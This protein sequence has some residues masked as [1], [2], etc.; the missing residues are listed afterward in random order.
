MRTVFVQTM[1]T[2]DG[3]IAGPDGDLSWAPPGMSGELMEWIARSLSG[4]D[5]ELLGRRSYQ[6]QV[7]TWPA[8][9]SPLA[10]IINGHDK[11]VFTSDPSQVDPAA[12]SGTR[13]STRTPS[14]EVADLKRVAGR[15]I[16]VP[17]GASLIHHLI[18]QDL[19]DEYR[20]ITHPVA[21]GTGLPLFTAPTRLELMD[22]RTFPNGVHVSTY[23]PAI[24]PQ[25]PGPSTR[26]SSSADHRP[27]PRP[28]ATSATA[29]SR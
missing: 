20:L 13:S 26:P 25:S 19:V 23:R 27:R 15:D 18:E 4:A 11:I 12:W 5:T 29:G 17:G 22:R 1:V 2:I 7:G 6:E 10:P 21:L 16:F 3:R 14:E 8:S 24:T 28:R 9:T